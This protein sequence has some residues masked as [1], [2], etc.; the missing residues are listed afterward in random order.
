MNIILC[1]DFNI[2]HEEIDLFN[3]KI[4]KNNTM[5]TIEERE[6]IKKIFSK[7]LV[8]SCRYM[9]KNEEEYIW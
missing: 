8:D 2:A 9:N 3:H 5:F 7:G 6:Q 4:N 1:G